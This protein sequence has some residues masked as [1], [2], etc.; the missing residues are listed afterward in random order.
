MTIEHKSISDPDIHEPKG[1]ASAL[2]DQVYIADGLGSGSWQA[3]PTTVPSPVGFLKGAVAQAKGD[4]TADWNVPVWKDLI[5]DIVPKTSGV[6]APTLAT[7]RGNIRGFAYSAGDDGDISFHLPHDYAPGSDL[8]LHM[9]WSHNSTAISGNFVVNFYVTYAKGHS[10]AT[11]PLE[12]ATSISAGGLNLTNTPQYTH[13]IDEIQ[14]T[15]ASPS[16][17]QFSSSLIEPD[18]LIM[19]HYDTASIPTL[20][21][22]AGEPFIL[23]IDLHYQANMVGTANKAPNF[24]S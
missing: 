24:Y 13:R 19:I 6:G 9:H 18:G 16:G 11:F 20:T 17:S 3:V 5:G 2:A 7:Y 15:A 1:A 10:Q 8:Y 4:G 22:G 12:I 21:G 14:L 23:F